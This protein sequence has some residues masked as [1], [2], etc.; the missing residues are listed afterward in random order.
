MGRVPKTTLS[1]SHACAQAG[2]VRCCVYYYK[3]SP[4]EQDVIIQSSLALGNMGLQERSSC[5]ASNCLYTLSVP[6]SQPILS[7]CL[8]LVPPVANSQASL[9]MGA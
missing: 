7:P 2:N 5:R 8:Q 4:K 6:A 3:C 9:F 1:P